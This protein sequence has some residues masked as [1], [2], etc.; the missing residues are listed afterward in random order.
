MDDTNIKKDKAYFISEIIGIKVWDRDFG[1]DFREYRR[2]WREAS[3]NHVLFDYPLQVDLELNCSCNYNCV[4]CPRKVIPGLEKGSMD[5]SLLF[6]I[7]DEGSKNGLCAINL[8]GL[9]EPLL[10]KDIADLISYA[11]KKGILDIMFHTNASLL[12]EKMSREIF[13]AGIT[14]I[15]FSLD[16]FR[17]KTYEEIRKGGNYDVVL[18]NILRFLELKE[19]KGRSY[20]MTRV[21]FVRMNKND[22]EVE[23]FINFWSDKVNVICIQ[24]YRNPLQSLETDLKAKTDRGYEKKGFICNQIFQRL[25]VRYN[26]L[27][28]PCCGDFGSNLIVGDATNSTIKGIWNSET[29]CKLRELQLS[30][31]YYDIK[32]CDMCVN[33]TQFSRQ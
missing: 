17:K 15:Q 7:I 2:K 12:T 14:R 16:A 32:T 27:T 20:P 22:A 31:K 9:G 3:E 11:K 10:R 21:S 29:I 23:D 19:K 6:R 25:Y 33:S 18:K 13:D 26:G 24:E 1:P 4:M 5:K 28:S 30:K 8:E